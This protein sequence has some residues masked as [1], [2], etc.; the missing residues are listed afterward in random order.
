MNLSV[1]LVMAFCMGIEVYKDTTSRL[2]GYGSVFVGS[3]TAGLDALDELEA[4]F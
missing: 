2:Y 1:A 4:V 3:E